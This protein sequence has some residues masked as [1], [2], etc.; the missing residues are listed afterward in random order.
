MEQMNNAMSTGWG[1][2]VKGIDELKQLTQDNLQ[3]GTMA[4]KGVSDRLSAQTE[5]IAALIQDA[6][7]A[8][9]FGFQRGDGGESLTGVLT[10]EELEARHNPKVSIQRDIEQGRHDDA[11]RKCLSTKNQQL[12]AWLLSFVN[13]DTVL[14]GPSES[15][16][17][18]PVII[19]LIQRIS[20]QIN[21]VEVEQRERF[22]EWMQM[23][24]LVLDETNRELQQH[25]KQYLEDAFASL[26]YH[27][28]SEDPNTR[29]TAAIVLG[30]INMKLRSLEVVLGRSQ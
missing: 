27:K 29:K 28:N 26:E 15:Q 1:G 9:S 5:N 19:G 14:M 10:A 30:M 25:I 6:T 23:L 11:F 21:E 24:V 8:G 4:L 13:P 7:E 2:F 18:Q 20:I 3:E 16:L 12:L 22:F 17:C